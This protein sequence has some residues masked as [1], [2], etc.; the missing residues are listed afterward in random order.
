M[1]TRITSSPHSHGTAQGSQR[2]GRQGA[3]CYRANLH[4][5]WCWWVLPALLCQWQHP[6]EA[7][8]VLPLILLCSCWRDFWLSTEPLWLSGSVWTYCFSW[9]RYLK[10]LSLFSSQNISLSQCWLFGCR[11]TAGICLPSNLPCQESVLASLPWVRPCP[12]PAS[13]LWTSLHIPISDQTFKV[14]ELGMGSPNRYTPKCR[15]SLDRS[16]TG[17]KPSVLAP[18]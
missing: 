14:N 5:C 8:E 7:A 2:Q 16:L 9:L 6:A 3:A 18:E 1:R 11:S 4:H 13:R 15:A 12:F 17:L 10:D